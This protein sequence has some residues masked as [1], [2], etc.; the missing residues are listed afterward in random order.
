MGSSDLRM[1][2]S[3]WPHPN[4]G[5][6]AHQHPWSRGW[7]CLWKRLSQRG[8][9]SSPGSWPFWALA[10]SLPPC[11]RAS[12]LAGAENRPRRARSGCACQGSPSELVGESR[13]DPTAS[14]SHPFPRG[15]PTEAQAITTAPLPS[16]RDPDLRAWVGASGSCPA[17][18]SRRLGLYR[19]P[20][21]VGFHFP[22]LFSKHI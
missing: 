4:F 21:R 13:L 15:V 7:S 9:S 10:S 6:R 17:L 18:S 19:R 14:A 16:S 5:D 22:F 8:L 11:W 12:C 1:G 20:A 2:H 3:E